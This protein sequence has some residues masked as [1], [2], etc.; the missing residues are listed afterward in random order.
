[1]LAPGYGRVLRLRSGREVRL[2]LERGATLLLAA[3]TGEV[4]LR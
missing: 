1:M 2:A 3:Q 4:V